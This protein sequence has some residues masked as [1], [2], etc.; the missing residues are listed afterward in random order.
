[1]IA[2]GLTVQGVALID[3]TDL[4]PA[5][6]PLMETGG[7]VIGLAFSPDGSTLAAVSYNGSVTVWNLESRALRY[8]PFRAGPPG[9]LAGVAIR[10]DGTMLVTSAYTGVK[11]F[12]TATGER[13]GGFADGSGSDLALS[14]D[15]RLA[16][17]A[18]H[19]T[20]LSGA[21]VWNVADRSLVLA[22][23]A[24]PTA[25]EYSVALSPDGRTLA[26]GGYGRFVRLYDVGTGD[27]LHA[28]DQ[29]AADEQGILEFTPDGRYLATRDALWDV[30]TGVRIGPRLADG[31]PTSMM[32]VSADGHHLL[33]TTEDGRG[34]VWDVDPASW[35][36]RACEVANRTLT[37]DEWETFLPGRPYEPACAP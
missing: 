8:E 10:A 4:T 31:L 11:L 15:G 1:L 20:S 6:P 25:D 35:P 27:L 34:F 18:A 3:A 26:V 24:D 32:D 37:R 13:L 33:V 14:A 5:G 23:E 28:L 30:A 21:E 19:W 7:P 22:V 12:D 2:V 36:Q 16:A 17:F 9:I 29:R